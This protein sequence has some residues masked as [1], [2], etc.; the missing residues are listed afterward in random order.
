MDIVTPVVGGIIGYFTNWL[1]IKMLFR[2]YTEKRIFNIRVPFTPGLMP[3]ERYELS[4]KVGAIIS[5][6]LLTQEVMVSALTSDDIHEN[7]DNLMDKI[8]QNLNNESRTI[9]QVLDR[10]LGDHQLVDDIIN[11]VIEIILSEV[12]KEESQV[13]IV[14]FMVSKAEYLLKTQANAFPIE[15][16]SLSIFNIFKDYGKEYINSEAF[17]Q[18]IKTNITGWSNCI[19]QNQRT[20]GEVLSNNTIERIKLTVSQKVEPVSNLVLEFIE[21]PEIEAKIKDFI[22]YL[23]NENVTKFITM[24]VS[25]TKIY[26]SI[27]KSFKEYLKDENNYVKTA[28]V[29]LNTIDRISD[30]RLSQINQKINYRSDYLADVVISSIR[31]FATED[32]FSNLLKSIS[33]FTVKLDKMNLYDIIINFEPDINKKTKHYLLNLIKNGTNNEA[34]RQNIGNMIKT[35]VNDVINLSIKDIT[36]IISLD[37]PMLNKTVLTIYDGVIKNGMLDILQAMNIAKIVENRIN[38]LDV[39]Q[40]EDIVLE[41]VK[42]ELRAITVIGGVL[43]FVIAL[44]PQIMQ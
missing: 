10:T 41:V 13:K 20:L 3:K 11:K 39:K 24:F 22:L 6:H 15:K 44:L 16:L 27:I 29:I 37:T 38:S 31:K 18:H 25:P 8:I 7:I 9:G 14:D 33:D 42:K 17:D 5:T 28:E 2:P 21:K 34:F 35:K 43:G 19:E 36:A 1:A 12:D 40:A 32:N 23:I 30:M 26:E 4:K